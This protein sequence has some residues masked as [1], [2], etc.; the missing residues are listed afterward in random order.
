MHQKRGRSS[1]ISSRVLTAVRSPSS[2]LRGLRVCTLYRG[3]K[4]RSRQSSPART[5]V[6]APSCRQRAGSAA[7]GGGHSDGGRSSS[8]RGSGRRHS[9]RTCCCGCSLNLL[10]ALPCSDDQLLRVSGPADDS[11]QHALLHLRCSSLSVAEP[12]TFYSLPETCGAHRYDCFSSQG[13]L[14]QPATDAA[15]RC[16]WWRAGRALCHLQ[17]ACC[18]AAFAAVMWLA[19]QPDMEN[20][21]ATIVGTVL[22]DWVGGPSLRGA[23]LGGRQAWTLIPRRSP[24]FARTSTG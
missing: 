19:F 18:G 9:G 8:R 21:D 11:R 7:G 17:L 2:S 12:K 4:P 15:A 1:L 10:R 13:S 6:W 14:A 22:W 5:W 23:G 20:E 24:A 3:V 16:C